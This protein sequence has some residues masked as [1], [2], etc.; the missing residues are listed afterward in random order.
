MKINKALP[1]V[2]ILV[3]P[4]LM[5]GQIVTPA[6]LTPAQ[7][8]ARPG[9]DSGVW[10][11]SGGTILA[12]AEETGG[13][14]TD[15]VDEWF[16]SPAI[17]LG[18]L[19]SPKVSFFSQRA[20]T[21]GTQAE[22]L[23]VWVSN[24]YNP[25]ALLNPANWT[26]LSASL[27]GANTNSRT[28]SGELDVGA[29]AA[30]PM[31]LAFRYRSSGR[32]AATSTQWVIDNV[33]VYSDSVSVPKTLALTLS[34]NTISESDGQNAATGTVTL[35]APA[36][37]MTTI[38][39]LAS[40]VGSLGIP[41]SLT[42][43]ANESSAS[44]PIHAI[45][46]GIV[47]GPRV[48]T[49]TASE[50]GYGSANATLTLLDSDEALAMTLETTV[51]SV[52]EATTMVLNGGKLSLNR[53]APV[54]GV[55]VSLTATPAGSLS[56]PATVFIPEG[57]TT[58][59]F[60]L[61]PIWNVED[62]ADTA[63]T[64]TATANGLTP[65]SAAITVTNRVPVA[66]L[67]F[68]R[69]TIGERPTV[70]PVTATL[71]L[72][73][74][75]RQNLTFELSYN[76]ASAISGPRS[77]VMGAGQTVTTFTLFP[78]VDA[79]TETDVELQVT[80]S[81]SKT[82]SATGGFTILNEPWGFEFTCQPSTV[83][84]TA[85][86]AALT[87]AISMSYPLPTDT[88]FVV[89]HTGRLSAPQRIVFPKNKTTLVTTIGV[90]DHSANT[91]N[92]SVTLTL[93]GP[94]GK[95]F[96]RSVMIQDVTRHLELMATRNSQRELRTVTLSI[97]RTLAEA[98][99]LLVR[100]SVEPE[101]AFEL[102]EFVIIPADT[103]GPIQVET[104]A[105]YRPDKADWT[106]VISA[107]ATD[108]APQTKEITIIDNTP[109]LDLLFNWNELREDAGRKEGLGNVLLMHA[110]PMDTVIELSADDGGRLIF[111]E[112]V[113]IPAGQTS[114]SFPIE[115]Q[116][117]GWHRGDHAVTFTGKSDGFPN[118]SATLKIIETDPLIQPEIKIEVATDRHRIKLGSTLLIS[119]TVSASASPLRYF[120]LLV[121]D[122]VVANSLTLALSYEWTPT[123]V[124]S[125][126]VT[127]RTMNEEN[128]GDV[129]EYA[130]LI[131]VVAPNPVNDNEQF[132]RQ[133]Y[134]DLLNAE[135]NADALRQATDRLNG[136]TPRGVLAKELLGDSG[137]EVIKGLHKAALILIGRPL[138]WEELHGEAS[139]SG[140]TGL[141]AK[142]KSEGYS[143]VTSALVGSADFT[144]AYGAASSMS[145]RAFF[146]IVY[147]LKYEMP[148]TA[149]QTAQG[150]SRITSADPRQG[151]GG[152][153][154]KFL[155]AIILDK[156]INN[157]DIIYGAPVVDFGKRSE[158]AML[159]SALWRM[160]PDAS[161]ADT[162]TDA[163]AWE[164]LDR[165]L[166]HPYYRDRFGAYVLDAYPL[167]NG[168]K[169]TYGL[170]YLYD[171]YWPWLYSP[172]VG[173]LWPANDNP[174]ALYLWSPVHDWLFSNDRW[175]QY[176]YRFRDGR[177]VDFAPWPNF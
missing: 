31:Y 72:E 46:D 19:E 2:W 165:L 4:L 87:L 27:P 63:V 67:T 43:E 103:V 51:T 118:M 23:T 163:V 30:E 9:S 69:A 75:P 111:P 91:G 107:V 140:L 169:W 54:G 59:R 42:I 110:L 102:P 129:E 56:V 148:P 176:A 154:G 20:R 21:D 177:L 52:E 38:A 127:A 94:G 33:R 8:T 138:R 106:A 162:L 86:A 134:M 104:R 6:Q 135:P 130:R 34:R 113:T 88:E 18:G 116:S 145:D 167:G 152:D 112:S 73:A 100:L 122:T 128:F 150:V 17:N 37:G 132:V 13:R 39:L 95:A 153:R 99:P 161:M 119:A 81:S 74:M 117:D 41:A 65:V 101:E 76:D 124:G 171:Y 115:S 143:A 172:T 109:R 47:R 98:K 82:T 70:L 151:F 144:K 160:L 44:F 71:T 173:W 35:S 157:A 142:E 50:T 155:E 97:S 146:E 126:R 93:V 12:D 36:E 15:S 175:N 123:A 137:I 120:E 164:E 60:D 16:V 170:G 22:P 5:S 174:E 40:E 32:T 89:S 28:Y 14:A 84:E 149:Q 131:E 49:L 48:I 141:A 77:V 45:S 133:L 3:W 121:N 156:K 53:A 83:V 85:G 26:K 80:A 11:V 64:L 96:S 68:D 158:K 55:Q 62:S 57:A 159:F 168:W 108:Y 166:W 29:F 7:F 78:V 147:Q 139:L 90:M 24:T 58:A 125:Y 114:V 92:Q 1:V 79:A 25:S 66:A 10:N 105:G 61:Q 136:G